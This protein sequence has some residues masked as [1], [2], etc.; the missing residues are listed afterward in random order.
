SFGHG[1]DTGIGPRFLHHRTGNER[2]NDAY[3]RHSVSPKLPDPLLRRLAHRRGRSGI[4][5]PMDEY[6][7]DPGHTK[8]TQRL[9]AGPGK[10]FAGNELLSH[11][12]APAVPSP[13]EGLTAV[14]GMGTG[15]SP[16]L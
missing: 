3:S 4:L 11:R 1:H 16:P 6:V 10:K 12:V 9:C 7:L 8:K 5:I 2:L 14:F 13:L 15:G